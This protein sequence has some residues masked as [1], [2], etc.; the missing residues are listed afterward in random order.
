MS[1]LISR[2]LMEDFENSRSLPAQ[3]AEAEQQTTGRLNPACA[4]FEEIEK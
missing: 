1:W 3:V 4:K 2:A